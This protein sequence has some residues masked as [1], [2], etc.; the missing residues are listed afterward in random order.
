MAPPRQHTMGG[1][2]GLG[3]GKIKISEARSGANDVRLGAK[4]WLSSLYDARADMVQRLVSARIHV[5]P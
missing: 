3:V 2:H 1:G 4:A 5:Y